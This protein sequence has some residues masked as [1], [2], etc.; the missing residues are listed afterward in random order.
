MSVLQ[1]SSATNYLLSSVLKLFLLRRASLVKLVVC[2]LAYLFLAGKVAISCS[3]FCRASPVQVNCIC[4]QEY[5]VYACCCIYFQRSTFRLHSICY[6][7]KFYVGMFYRF[8]STEVSPMYG[9]YNRR[10]LSIYS[11]FR[12]QCVCQTCS[13]RCWSAQRA[14][15]SGKVCLS[16]CR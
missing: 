13:T 11:I 1:L 9:F 7:L 16:H 12:A 5:T 2:K 6:S 8:A 4:M 10:D 15:I 14:T 3:I